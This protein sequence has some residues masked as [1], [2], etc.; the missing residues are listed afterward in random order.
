MAFDVSGDAYGKFMGSFSTGLSSSFADFCGVLDSS[1]EQVLDVGCGP[2]VLTSELVERLGPDSVRAIDPSGSFVTA[3]RERLPGVDVRQGSGE[4][5]PFADGSFDAAL[6]QLVLPFMQ[7]ARVGLQEMTRVCR[8][9]GTVG[10]SF[11]DHVGGRGPVSAFWTAVQALDP[12]ASGESQMVTVQRGYIPGLMTEVGLLDVIDTELTTTVHFETFEQ[13][14]APYLLGVGPA[15]DYVASLEE[16]G[17]DALRQ[18]C[19]DVLGPGPFDVT[20]VAWAA[21]GTVPA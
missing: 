14:W 18:G 11:W 3:C 13:W 16:H 7:D 2:G 10:G 15:G 17:V 21:R 12:L 20:A 6:A 19:L 5:L 8:P 1:G 9:G 4:Q